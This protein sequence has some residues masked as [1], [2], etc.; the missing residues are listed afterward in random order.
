MTS[1]SD[2]RRIR[3]GIIGSATAAD[4]VAAVVLFCLLNF[5]MAGPDD[6][7]RDALVSFLIVSVVAFPGAA[8]L[9]ALLFRPVERWL[10]AG[11]PPTATEVAFVMGGPRRT[12]WV[13]FGF[14]VATAAIIGGVETLDGGPAVEGV[15]ELRGRHNPTAA[16]APTG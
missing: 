7:P 15:R 13:A 10:R 12:A 1:P 9:A 16:F 5:L 3:N 14:W 8:A 6:D 4:F 11:R 2:A